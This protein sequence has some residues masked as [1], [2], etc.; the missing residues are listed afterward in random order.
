M[1]MSKLGIEIL[2]NALKEQVKKLPQCNNCYFKHGKEICF[3]A[4]NCL[5]EEKEFSYYKPIKKDVSK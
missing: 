5:I 1:K 4:F 3:F 2:D